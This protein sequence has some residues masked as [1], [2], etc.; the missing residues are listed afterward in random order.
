M[1]KGRQH[2]TWE[3]LAL[4]CRSQEVSVYVGASTQE[5]TLPVEGSRAHLLRLITVLWF[6]GLSM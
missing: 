4:S 6:G 5:V 2:L 1:L 3:E